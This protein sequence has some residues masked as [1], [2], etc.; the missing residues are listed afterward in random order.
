MKGSNT[1]PTQAEID[2]ANY[3]VHSVL[4]SQEHNDI[5]NIIEI[6]MSLENDVFSNIFSTYD[7]DNQQVGLISNV[8]DSSGSAFN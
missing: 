1:D 4:T 5:V 8:D 7:Q 6:Y 3:L 2:S